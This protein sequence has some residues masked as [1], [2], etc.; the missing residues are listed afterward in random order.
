[1]RASRASVGPRS[2]GEVARQHASGWNE[3][4]LRLKP[5]RK[6]WRETAICTD[7]DD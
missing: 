4:A 1:M 7:L 5:E 3:G 6:F 2:P